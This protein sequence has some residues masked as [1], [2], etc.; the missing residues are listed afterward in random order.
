MAGAPAAAADNAF[1]PQVERAG[2]TMTTNN[3]DWF[4]TPP[5]YRYAWFRCTGALTTSCTQI[6]GAA[7][8]SYILRT[9]DIGYRIR[10]RVSD[11]SGGDPTYSSNQVGPIVAA[12]PK[13]TAA[14]RVTGTTVSGSTLRAAAGT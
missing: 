6:P 10:S 5:G 9:A 11:S 7:A 13:S 3:G 4:P 14:P 8:R 12:P 2:R 1:P